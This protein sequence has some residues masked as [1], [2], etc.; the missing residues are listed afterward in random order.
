AQGEAAEAATSGPLVAALDTTSSGDPPAWAVVALVLAV[1]IR[2]GLVPLHTWKTDLFEHA[3]FGGS[4]LMASSLGGA[5]AAVR[6]LLPTAPDW[7]L[8]LLGG[9]SLATAVYASG[10][11]LVQN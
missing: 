2:G 10:M 5:Y 8:S 3:T 11:A 7:A 1:W 4:L 9:A 6:L